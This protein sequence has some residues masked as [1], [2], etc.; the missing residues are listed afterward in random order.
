MTFYAI[1]GS[2]RKRGNTAVLLDKALQGVKDVIPD[3]DTKIIHV[4]DYSYTG[5][6]SCY[7]C[8]RK[9]EASIYGAVRQKGCDLFASAGTLAGRW[10]YHRV[11]GIFS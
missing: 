9:G 2:P 8:K 1:N 11:S 5:C 3:A 6:V 4:Y 10:A 7:A